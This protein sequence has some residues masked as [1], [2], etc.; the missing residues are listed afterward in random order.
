MLRPISPKPPRG[1]ILR[2]RL[3]AVS[4]S[5]VSVVMVIFRNQ[6]RYLCVA[7]FDPA[8]AGCSESANRVEGAP[9]GAVGDERPLRIPLPLE[10]L[11]HGPE[12]CGGRLNQGTPRSI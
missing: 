6:L 2:P 5:V 4:L 11:S 10:L 12:P 1:M 9:E 7:Q 3:S 8:P